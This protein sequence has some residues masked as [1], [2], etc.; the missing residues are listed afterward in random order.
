MHADPME[1]WTLREDL[2]LRPSGFFREPRC[3]EVLAERV[4]PALLERGPGEAR[5]LR[6]WVPGCATGEEV[7]SI[8]ML[9]AEVLG[10]ARPPAEDGV[11]AGSAAGSSSGFTFQIFGS[12]VSRRAIE[13]ARRAIYPASI[14]RDVGSERLRRFFTEVDGGYRLDRSIRDR[15]VFVRH[16]LTRDPS[17]TRLDL[18]ICRGVLDALAPEHRQRIVPLLQFAL[19]APGF[20]MLGRGEDLGVHAHLFDPAGGESALYR[21]RPEP[22]RRAAG[23]PAAEALRLRA[24]GARWLEAPPPAGELQRAADHLL[25]ARYGPPA[26][27]VDEA[28][29]VVGTRGRIE[30]YL[31]LSPGQV[32]LDV[33]ARAREGLLAGLR[34]ALH[35]ARQR[36]AAVRRGAVVR[37]GGELR[38]VRI[39]IT[40]LPGDAARGR[41][42]LVVFLDAPAEARPS[43][44]G[45]SSRRGRSR[46]AGR[47]P[48]LQGQSVRSLRDELDGA[49]GYLQAVIADHSSAH[50]ELAAV[51]EELAASNEELQCMIDELEAA[52]EELAAGNEVLSAANAE[53]LRR[54]AE[55]TQANN[56]L[57]NVMASI[58]VPIVLVGIDR[59]IRRFTPRAAEA[60]SLIAADVGRPIGDLNLNVEAPDLDRSIARVIA[61]D[62]LEEAEVRD[63]EGRWYRL[64]IRPYRTARAQIDG[65][66]VSLVDIDAPKRALEERERLLAQIRRERGFLEAVVQQLPA[67]VMIAEAPSGRPLLGNRRVAEILGPRGGAPAAV[68]YEAYRGR[69]AD[70]RPYA[71]EEWPL[72]RSL[73]RGEVVTGEQI[74]VERSDGSVATVLA[75][76]APIRDPDGKIVAGVIAF[77]D[78]SPELEVRARLDREQQLLA[79]TGMLLGELLDVERALERTLRLLV[80]RAA[81]WCVLDLADEAGA[82][83]QVAVAHADP[84]REALVRALARRLPPDPEL[85]YGLGHVLRTRRSELH[86][87]VDDPAWAAGALSIEDPERLRALGARSY[88][89][90]PLVARDQLVGVLSLVRGDGA[91]LFDDQSLRLAEDLAHRFALAIDNA[92]LHRTTLEAVRARNE[93][94]SIAAHELRTPLGALLLQ[95]QTMRLRAEMSGAPIDP[96]ELKRFAM[97]E[98]QAQR[99]DALVTTLLDVTRIAAGR[100]ALDRAEVD[101]ASLVLEVAARFEDQ[102]QLAGCALTVRAPA[103]VR[104]RWDRMRIE[105]VATN[106][107]SN[108]LK[109]G[110]R[111]PI[112]VTVEAGGDVARLVVRDFGIGIAPQDLERIFGQFERAVPVHHYVGLGMGLFI[113]R[114]IVEAHGGTVRASSELGAGATFTV[115]LPLR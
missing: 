42:F 97:L 71:P 27:I 75:T 68:A 38:P 90:V 60:M 77:V 20:L 85:A 40:P 5:T 89:C 110:S 25:Q 37:V 54:N 48:R 16:D 1:A 14:A 36:D 45:R 76:S 99:L 80:P 81:D 114:Q 2:C 15:C 58:E 105:Q 111:R 24:A 44:R 74:S 30:A 100:I 73:H 19:R 67:A 10:A 23:A 84:E 56:D 83:R 109:Y 55:L 92:R 17:F 79:E 33:L 72:A 69:R 115:E 94:F 21:R 53:A 39:E 41:H 87:L 95:V 11:P 28:L 47:A 3:F 13:H 112:V 32:G 107:L 31:D 51:N 4:L 12:D 104:G 46:P 86:A 8:A 34:P 62:H 22:A 98:R 108:G 43:A 102:A 29:T 64:Q 91:A 35:R 113:T 26:V 49:K 65:A 9:F 52:K 59:R 7:Y 61:T 50:E 70:G 63:R 66:I 78:L 18:V 101:L 57:F 103:P 82:L 96:A 88:L 6:A 93:F 106:L